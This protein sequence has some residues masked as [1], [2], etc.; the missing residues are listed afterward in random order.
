VLKSYPFKSLVACHLLLILLVSS[1]SSQKKVQRFLDKQ[2]LTPEQNSEFTGLLMVDAQS[3]DTLMSLNPGRYFTPASTAKVFTLYAALKVLPGRI[4]TLKYKVGG[5]TLHVMGTGD[6]STLHPVLGDSSAIE[7]IRGYR[8][9][10]LHSG[11]LEEAAWGAGWAWDDFDQSYQVERSALP[12]YGNVLRLNPGVEG[13]QISPLIFSDSVIYGK[14]SYRRT[15]E[16]NQ[17]FY[18]NTSLDTITIPLTLGDELTRLLWEEALGRTLI[19]GASLPEGPWEILPGI[20]SD[21]LYREMMAV[22]DNFLA[23]QLMLLVSSTL[24]DSLSF[25][26]ARDY[27]LNTHLRAMPSP[28]KWVD[29]SGLSRYNLIS[30]ESLVYVLGE[31]YREI[32]EDRLFAIMA[33][34]GERGTLKDWYRDPEGPFLF[35][36]TGTLSNNHNL[37]GYLKTRSGKTVIFSFMNNHYMKPTALV[38]SRMQRLLLWV[39][40]NY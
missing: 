16:G 21:T 26:R 37:C 9:I 6:P 22:S 18:N 25:K 10:V 36:K 39:R 28:P 14:S 29:G 5:D 2:L 32:P 3:G 12:I 30:P 11:T 40:E 27:I 33:K 1:C 7:F 31:L 4:P 15:P 24:S 34:G 17:F 35:G 13:L 8:H 38:K 23:E 19:Q 20:P